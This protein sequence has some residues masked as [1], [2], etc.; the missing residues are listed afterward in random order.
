M[1]ACPDTTHSPRSGSSA[2]RCR[3]AATGCP[4]LRVAPHR[5]YCLCRVRYSGRRFHVTSCMHMSVLS[6]PNGTAIVT[7]KY[8]KSAESV[9]KCVGGRCES[10]DSAGQV[11]FGSFTEYGFFTPNLRF[12]LG[13]AIGFTHGF[14]RLRGFCPGSA[15]SCSEGRGSLRIQQNRKRIMRFFGS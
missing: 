8:V 15:R 10:T 14:E 12:V 6:A 13:S 2:V 11:G 1:R 4:P 9:A 5:R 3:S 7:G